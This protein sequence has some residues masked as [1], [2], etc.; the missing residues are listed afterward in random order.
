MEAAISGLPNRIAMPSANLLPA[1][2]QPGISG[3]FL[4]PTPFHTTLSS[5]AKETSGSPSSAATK[6]AFST[7]QPI[8]SSKL[9]RQPLTVTPT[10]LPESL[11][12]R[13]GSPRITRQKLAASPPPT[14]Q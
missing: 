6:S 8:Q 1:A 13:S 12:D 2:R 9:Q 14:P 7:K 10:V 4:Q 3:R 11:V 5:M